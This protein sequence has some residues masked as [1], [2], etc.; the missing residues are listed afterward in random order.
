MCC[1][2]VEKENSSGKFVLP[3]VNMFNIFFPC[4]VFHEF[5]YVIMLCFIIFFLGKSLCVAS[6]LYN[7]S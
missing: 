1:I 2:N 5:R 4:T 7:L 6:V 3:R